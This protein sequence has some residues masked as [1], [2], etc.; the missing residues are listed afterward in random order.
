VSR[1]ALVSIGSGPQQ[2][3][4]AI[5]RR[6]FAPYAKRHGYDLI[7]RHDSPADGR[8]APW[9]KVVLLRELA[10]RYDTLVWLDAD[11]VIV[12][13]RR[14]IAL[15]LDDG[16]DVALVEHSYDDARMPNSGV[17][18]LRGGKPAVS[19]LDAVWELDQFTDHRWWENA[20]ICSLLGYDLD[21]PRPAAPTPWREATTFLDPRWNSI[22]N[23]PAKRP[24]IRHYPGYSLKTRAAFMI[25]DLA[26]S[27][28]R[29][30]QR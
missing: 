1:R 17:M 2:R 18:V 8:P 25:R 24:Y 6:S 11:L 3:L 30:R 29:G 15:E 13:G 26:V 19:F 14:D 4:L 27:A 20:A 23:A 7:L 12:D 10:P 21:P 28:A 5:A 16:K 9:G 22:R